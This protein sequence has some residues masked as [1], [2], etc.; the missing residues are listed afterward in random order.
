MHAQPY[1]LTSSYLLLSLVHLAST[2]GLSDAPLRG[3]G[4]RSFQLHLEIRLLQLIF[5]AQE[6]SSGATSLRDLRR[7][8][9]CG[10]RR[11]HTIDVCVAGE[12]GDDGRTRRPHESLADPG[13]FRQENLV[14]AL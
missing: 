11:V 13:V 14:A 1:Q 4:F 6:P 5:H 2:N 9:R 8:L 3:I 12:L 7:E 10:P